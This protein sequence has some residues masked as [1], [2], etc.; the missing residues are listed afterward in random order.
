MPDCEGVEY[1][2]R[3]QLLLNTDGATPTIIKENGGNGMKHKCYWTANKIKNVIKELDGITWLEGRTL[4]VRFVNDENMLGEVVF[5]DGEPVEFQFS[6]RF[7]KD[8]YL[9]YS[10][11]IDTI[12]RQYAKYMNYMLNCEIGETKS[13]VECCRELM[14]TPEYGFNLS[15]FQKY[16]D[17]L[18][19]NGVAMNIKEADNMVECCRIGERVVI[20]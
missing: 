7:L 11:A 4:P 6:N 13:F 14:C 8:P 15:R 19:K 9:P 16:R 2:N 3:D 17:N 5:M 20:L 18:K 12:K 1:H 10:F